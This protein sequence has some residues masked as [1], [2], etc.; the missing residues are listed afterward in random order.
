MKKSRFIKI[1]SGVMAAIFACAAL[2]GCGGEDVAEVSGKLTYWAPINGNA[3]NFASNWDDLPLYQKLQEN[4]GI[5]IEFMHPSGAAVAEQFSIL[6]ASTELPDLIQY[7]WSKYAGGP[8]RAIEDG[9]IIDLYEYKDKLPNLMKYLDENEEVKKNAVTNDGKLFAAPFVRG[10][11]SLCVSLGLAMRQD[12]LDDLGLE[13]PETIDE[14]DTV[15]TAFQEKKGAKAPLQI[16]LDSLKY[17]LFSGA[18][19]T[20]YDY[21]LRE[22]KVTHGFLDPGFKD[23]LMQLNDWYERGILN[24]DFAATDGKTIDANML[25]GETGAMQMTLGGGI[26]KY[27]SAAEGSFDLVGV[28]SPVLNKGDYPEFG[29]YQTQIPTTQNSVFTA[30]SADCKN[31]DAALKFL[32]YGYTEEG[33]MLY[34]FGIEGES[35]NMVD[36]YPKYTEDIT[37]NAEGYSMAVML[38]KYTAS[39]DA[40]PFIQD[41]RYM[42]Q[43]A[44]R[45]Q[46][47]AAW[48]IWTQSNM[49]EHLLPNLYVGEE[50]QKALSK[51][52]TDLRSYMDEKVVKLIMGTESFDSYDDIINELKKRGIEEALTIY[53]RAYESW[54]TR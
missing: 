12:W 42:E 2:A 17:G 31:I 35:Y 45:P 23:L 7:N 1:I 44:A 43:Y 49:S 3:T 40:G 32:D 34:N 27:L 50:D 37:S 10:D 28:K 36:G 39:Y 29:F 33:C 47:Q 19:N 41:T 9:V 11:K 5:D 14:W 30:I 20:V 16:G 21:Y 51:I 54:L 38:S 52:E 15:L 18:Y 53:Q 46:Q 22:G 4:T 13:A 26:G 48:D 8:G 24:K 6:M 25:N